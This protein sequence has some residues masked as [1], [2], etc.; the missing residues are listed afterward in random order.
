LVA[1][2]CGLPKPKGLLGLPQGRLCMQW[3]LV[4]LIN[5]PNIFNK[6]REEIKSLVGSVRLVEE[7][8]VSSLPYLQAVV[9]E[10]LRLHP[11]LP[12]IVR[13]CRE[14]CKIKDF[15]IPKKTMLA[16]NVYAIMRDANIWDYPNDFRP[17][18]FLISSK[19]K[20]GMDTTKNLVYF[21]AFISRVH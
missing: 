10:A 20:D 7:S 21:N 5:H 11:P 14:A 3:T 6:V 19:D 13:E 2:G 9:K 12:V 18:R 1:L 17:E 16:I 4:E 15:E 8:D